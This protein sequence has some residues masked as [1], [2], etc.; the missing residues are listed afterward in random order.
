MGIGFGPVLFRAITSQLVFPERRPVC[1]DFILGQRLHPVGRS[2][3]RHRC[4][5]RER[6]PLASGALSLLETEYGLGDN[7][8]TRYEVLAPGD[9]CVGRIWEDGR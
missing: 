7:S 2:L 9:R 1:D 5:Q 3:W 8:G 6:A 4:A